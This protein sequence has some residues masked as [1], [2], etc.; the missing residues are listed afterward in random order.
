MYHKD[1]ILVTVEDWARGVFRM[2]R[3]PFRKQQ[4]EQIKKA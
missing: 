4:A 2:E 1:H 3:E